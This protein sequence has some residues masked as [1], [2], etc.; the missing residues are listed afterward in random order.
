M[1]SIR[2]VAMAALG[3]VVCLATVAPGLRATEPTA[4]FGVYEYV[5]ERAQG[6]VDEV[7]RAVEA[8]VSAAGWHVL[9]SVNPGVP[10]G[11]RFRARVLAVV[12]PAYAARLMAV[13]RRTAPFA[14][15]DRINVFEDEAG[16]HVSVVNTESVSRTVLMDDATQAE[17]SR[18]HLLALRAVIERAV[19]G[20][21]SSREYGE[22]R[23]RG[24]I[25]KTMGVMAGGPFADKVIDAATVGGDD[26]RGVA[27]RVGRGL[28]A[29]GPKWGLHLA[30]TLE[31]PELEA[32]IFGA[33]GTPMDSQSFRIV[34][35]GGSDARSAFACPGLAHAGAYPIE[36]VVSREGDS[37][38][39][40]MVDAMYRMKLYFEDA[41]KWAF[42]KNMGMPGSIHDELVAQ[43]AAGLSSKQ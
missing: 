31:L 24:F 36:V 10:S 11:C 14:V 27:D 3:T 19:P 20:H 1:H 32:V 21:V 40:R 9:G 29:R 42:M 17:A 4:R 25:G 6:N 7:S 39:V 5:I 30:Y 8:A 37:V 22:V 35:A 33:T 13:N 41:G 15:V 16:V 38:R 26:W 12:D 34:G 23:S 2:R 43:I 28:T 18:T